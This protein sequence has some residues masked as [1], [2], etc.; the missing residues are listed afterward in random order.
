MLEVYNGDVKISDTY[1]LGWRYTA[2]DS[3][4]YNWITNSYSSGIQ[5]K[6]GSWTSGTTVVCHD[7][8][9]YISASWLSR[10]SILQNGNIGIGTTAPQSPLHIIAA[11]SADNA[12]FQEWS[13]TS[14]STDIFSLMLKQTVTANVV[15]Y[16]FSMVN[17]STAYDNML[18]FDRGNIGIGTTS[19]S[20]PLH[21]ANTGVYQITAEQTL[22]DTNNVNA[23]ATFYVINNAGSSQVRGI[24]GAGGNNVNNTALRN[25]VYYGAQSNHQTVFLTN[26]AERM[27]IT[28]GGFV[29][30]NN[31]ANTTYQLY[32]NGTIY[33]TGDVIA[34][35]DK[36]VKTNIRSIE[37][38]IQ[39]IM[40]SRGVLYD[41]TDID[42]KDNMGFIAQELEEQFP[43]LISTDNKGVKGVKYQNAVAVLFEAIKEQQNQINELKNI[44][45]ATTK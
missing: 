19:P 32:V 4:M 40:K 27:R 12:L 20:Y 5:Y 25:A 22:T 28:S 24:F 38:P 31:T 37:N 21:V 36:S 9:T 34:Y 3:N 26:D 17:N 16:N 39:K 35:S 45:N 7:F 23:Y 42:S 41:R 8:Q 13:Y 14:A 43:E 30:I 1:R 11:S 15:R 18:V 29:N 44:I 2:G 10:L 6:S 33:A